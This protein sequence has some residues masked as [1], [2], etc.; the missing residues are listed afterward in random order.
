[1]K[2]FLAIVALVSSVSISAAQ[3]V[4]TE[5]VRVFEHPGLLDVAYS[6]DRHLCPRPGMMRFSVR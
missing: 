2:H 3:D 5:P 4:A 6:P 1:M